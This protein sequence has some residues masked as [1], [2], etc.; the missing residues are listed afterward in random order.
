MS[1]LSQQELLKRIREINKDPCL[2]DAEKA[3]ARQDLMSG[4]WKEKVAPSEDTEGTKSK[5]ERRRP[6][7][8]FPPLNAAPLPCL[9]ASLARPPR[10][11]A[12]EDKGKGA[13]SKS[14]AADSLLDDDT[15]KCAICFDLCVRPVTVSAARDS[16]S[17][18]ALLCVVGV[19]AGACYPL[20]DLCRRYQG[21]LLAEGY[22]AAARV[23]G[24]CCCSHQQAAGLCDSVSG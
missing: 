19:G 11:A 10:P 7:A 6:P 21:G 14:E 3:A 5:S 17:R 12:A 8:R 22:A 2:S 16:S 24:A 20:L 13:A 9:P 23:A 18:A 15:L 1:G 4:K